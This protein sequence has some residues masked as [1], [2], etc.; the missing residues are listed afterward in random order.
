MSTARV[1]NIRFCPLVAK[2]NMWMASVKEEEHAPFGKNDYS[3]E[4][5][6]STR[7]DSP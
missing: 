1:A 2:E 4:T 7:N 6:M 3:S 5:S